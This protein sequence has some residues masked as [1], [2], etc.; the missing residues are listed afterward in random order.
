[1]TQ[2]VKAMATK[3]EDQVLICDTHTV[4]RTDS[5]LVSLCHSH[6]HHD[7]CIHT[8]THSHSQINII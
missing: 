1:M 7:T 6:A 5:L 4:G 8:H 3:S 2:Q